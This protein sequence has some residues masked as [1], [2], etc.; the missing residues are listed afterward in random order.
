MKPGSRTCTAREL[1]N[2]GSGRKSTCSRCASGASRCSALHALEERGR[3]GDDEHQPG[4]PTGVD[5]V[6]ELPQRV[7]R[8]VP[9]V[10]THPLQGLDFVQHDDQPVVPAVAQHHEQPLQEA[11]RGVVVQITADAGDALD[12]RRDVRLTAEPR[13]ES[14]RDRGVAGDDGP[15]VGPQR[16]RERRGDP[17]DGAQA[18]LEDRLQPCVERRRRNTLVEDVL[19]EGEQPRVDERTQ[20]A[21]RV[22]RGAQPFDKPSIDGLQ[23]VQRGLV[24]R[25]LDLGTGEPAPLGPLRHPPGDERLAGPVVAAHRLGR[26]RHR[27]RRGRGR[28]P[29]RRRTGPDRRRARRARAAARSRGAGCR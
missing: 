27:R 17:A 15:T 13:D 26:R 14:L 11:E 18:L 22:L 9:H 16:G 25:D 10:R 1:S 7:E 28:R 8:L 4:E 23:P 3:P 12:R 21:R 19:L 29:R 20:R 5:V 6:D 24:L 2:R